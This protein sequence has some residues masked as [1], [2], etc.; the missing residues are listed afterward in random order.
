MAANLTGGVR[1]PYISGIYFLDA[2]GVPQIAST[3]TPFPT[4]SSGGG[5][6]STVTGT[7][8][9]NNA[10]PAATNI[11]ALVGLANASAPT[12]TEGNQVLLSTDLSGNLRTIGTS[13]V[14]YA[15]PTTSTFTQAAISFSAS[16]DNT[17]VAA[18]SAKTTR[19]YQITYVCSG[20][21]AI[22]IKNGAGAS[23]TGAMAFNAG[24]SLTLDFVPNPRFVTST[25]TAFILNSSNAVQ[26]SG[27]VDYTQS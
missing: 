25:N 21:T 1:G 5:G 16:G 10:A 23:L 14:S 6:G 17:V 2:N 12:F 18:V 13:T 8:T 22:T 15:T 27:W 11:G 9:N 26:V 3:A 24:G 19:I 20:A 7:L 4:T